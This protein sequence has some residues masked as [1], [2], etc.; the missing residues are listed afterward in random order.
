MSIWTTLVEVAYDTAVDT[1][2]EVGSKSAEFAADM[3]QV[4][5]L[6]ADEAQAL[7]D[8]DPL[9]ASIGVAV[10]LAATAALAYSGAGIAEEAAAAIAESGALSTGQA[11]IATT[12][13]RA[14][15]A[16]YAGGKVGDLAAQ[17]LHDLYQKQ[18]HDTNIAEADRL[19]RRS[20]I[21]PLVIDFSGNGIN[22]TNVATSS[23]FFNWTPVGFANHDFANQ[24]GWIGSGNGFIAVDANGD[25]R[26]ASDELINSFYTLS[27]YD[28]NHDGIINA[29]DAQFDNLQIWV[30]ANQNGQ[31]DNGELISCH[32][33]PLP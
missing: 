19:L 31:T 29:S 33:R 21:D 8:E 15:L 14:I 4:Y 7:V 26:I 9:A 11:T 27:A 13:L 2:S 28:S 32:K 5:G 10:A 1:M 16:N 6:T 12:V 30:D 25:G 17:H 20:I 22:L 23:T 3:L 18:E 24:T